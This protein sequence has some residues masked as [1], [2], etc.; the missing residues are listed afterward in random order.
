MF[1]D[2]THGNAEPL[3]D[4][5][6]GFAIDT[7]ANENLAGSG[8]E[9]RERA[10]QCSDG[11]ARLQCCVF[12]W[13]PGTELFRQYIGEHMMPPRC[14]QVMIDRSVPGCSIENTLVVFIRAVSPGGKHPG[15]DILDDLRS[16]FTITDPATHERFEM[17]AM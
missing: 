5:G 6:I 3:S 17:S 4:L 13:L 7:S 8:G 10:I 1:F 12:R 9:L 14:R 15:E 11:L 16:H 2:G